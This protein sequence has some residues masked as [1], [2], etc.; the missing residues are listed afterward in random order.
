MSLE[1]RELRGPDADPEAMAPLRAL[2]GRVL[3]PGRPPSA[4]VFPG[5][6]AAD[7]L[8]LAVFAPEDGPCVGIASIYHENGLRLRGMAVDPDWQGKGVGALLIRRLQEVAGERDLDLWCN[9]RVSALGFYEKL[10]W[11]IEGAEFDVPD[12]GPHYIMRW[13]RPG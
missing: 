8:H 1:I 11:V 7:T 9:A 13:R 5:D 3:R 6:E 4:S 10:G 2:R 12:V